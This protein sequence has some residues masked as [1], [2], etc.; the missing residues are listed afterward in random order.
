[1]KGEPIK[2]SATAGIL[3]IKIKDREIINERIDNQWLFDLTLTK[4]ITYKEAMYAEA[5]ICAFEGDYLGE[6]DLRESY[7]N[8]KRY[9]AHYELVQNY[10][11]QINQ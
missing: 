3:S 11:N 6:K 5:N 7:N 8:F 9:V 4:A 10:I 1:M 2:V